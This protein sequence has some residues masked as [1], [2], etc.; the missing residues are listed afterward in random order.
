MDIPHTCPFPL[1]IVP[2][3]FRSTLTLY[4]FQGHYA[5]TYHMAGLYRR[6]SETHVLHKVTRADVAED[7][8]SK[9]A[10]RFVNETDNIQE[11]FDWNSICKTRI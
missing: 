8:E 10:V 9:T 11:D 6:R 3:Y 5:T 1:A 4:R 7:A 2:I